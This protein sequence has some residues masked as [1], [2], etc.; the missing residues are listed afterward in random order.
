MKRKIAILLAA[1]MTSAM[2]PMNVMAASSTNV[3]KTVTVADDDYVSG[4]YLKIQP[5]DEIV[6]GD[7]IVI[8]AVNGEFDPEFKKDG[9]A[10][11]ANG[12]KDWQ[13]SQNSYD[14]DAACNLIARYGSGT[15]GETVYFTKDML[16]RNNND[17]LPYF[18]V[19][20]SKQEIEVKLFPISA[21]AS[22]KD[23]V[24]GNKPYYYIPMNLVAKGTGDIEV[25]IDANETTISGGGTYPIATATNSSGSTTTTIE[26]VNSFEDS[27]YLPTITVKENVKGT[28]DTSKS[29]GY[30]TVRLSGGFLFADS[31]NANFKF[32]V[33]PGVNATFTT[34]TDY[35]IDEDEL[36]FKLPTELN[37]T[38]KASAFKISNLRVIP[39]DE[40]DDWGD[41]NITISGCNITK[42]TIKVAERADYGFKMTATE[43]PTTLIAG[44]FE[45]ANDDIDDDDCV[46]AKVKFEETIQNTWISQRKLEFTV[47]DGIKIYKAEFENEENIEDLESAD[48]VNITNDGQ[49][50]QI[51]KGVDLS[52]NDDCV[53]FEMKLYLSADADYEGEVALSCAGGGVAEGVI[54]DVVIANVVAPVT[55]ETTSTK[56]NMGYQTYDT[57]DITITEAQEG[58][59][60]K[61]KEVWLELDAG[62]GTGE[63]GFSDDGTID[64]EIDGDIQIKNF[65]I[66][67]GMIKFTVDKTSYNE[68][69]SITIKNV[70]VGT[71]RSVP[72]GSYDLKLYGPAVVN[73]YDEDKTDDATYPVK[74]NG[75]D[76]KNLGY[77]DTTE[78]YAFPEYLTIATQTG[79]L[80][81]VVKVAIDD[82][83]ILINDVAY[84]MDTAAY[85]QTSSN[86]T[87]VPL[88]FV[89][90]ALGVDD[91]LTGVDG[92]DQSS[93]ISWNANTKTATIYYGA[94]TGQKIIQ[95]TAGSNNMV[96][97][98]TTIPME[99][100]VV[101]EIKDDRMFVPFRALGQA[102]GVAVSW[103]EETRTAIYNQK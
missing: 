81:A 36:K 30:V 68:P 60:L 86:S 10:V 2:I 40:D 61:N 56:L 80:D 48:V 85:I 75:G 99:Y 27:I 98:G 7:S 91:S 57:A 101:A 31:D 42:E 13:Y 73:N 74:L 15:A 88:R 63:L 37:D 32:E 72:Y 92:A 34:I 84:D 83:T 78:A 100:G 79:T 18:I 14:W 67:G 65:K 54:D 5:N 12:V 93:K 90:L 1:V 20:N 38:D 102:L 4:V 17:Q 44:R 11:W 95:F 89:S 55:I 33:T 39:D 19:V 70:K 58:I 43:D 71:T 62:F 64:Y 8:T 21:S 49:T 94:G 41:V 50:L 45:L 82:P 52:S 29:N 53:E 69:A 87:M 9:K 26:E 35:T 77:F 47:P 59:F 22:G 103:D 16:F 24:N 28:F 51:N 97:D 96:V 6:S 66:S 25:K 23:N 46:A 3:N 76:L